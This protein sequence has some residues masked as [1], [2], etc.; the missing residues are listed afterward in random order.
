MIDFQGLFFGVQGPL[1]GNNQLFNLLKIE[2]HTTRITPEK[3]KKV[4]FHPGFSPPSNFDH[5][6]A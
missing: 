3:A 5:Q 1:I 6:K 2:D 4:P